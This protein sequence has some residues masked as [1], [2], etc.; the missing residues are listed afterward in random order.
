MKNRILSTILLLVLLVSLTGNAQAISPAMP[1]R[2]ALVYVT[3]GSPDDLSGFASTGLPMYTQ[4]D[5]AL[6]TGADRAGQQAL[7]AIGLNFQVIDPD[8]RAGTYYLAETR[9]GHPAPE[10]AAYGQ[11]LLHTGNLVL[12][13]MDPSQVDPLTQAGVELQAVTLTPKPLP[14]TAQEEGIFPQAV[15]PDPIIQG[16]IDQVTEEQVYTYDRQLAGELP[17]WVDGGWYTITS[18]NTNSGTPIQKTMHYVGQHMADLPGMDVEY[19]VWS[20][21]TNPNVIGEIPGLVNPDDIFIIGA[22]IDDVNGT[23][24]ADDNASGSVATLLA[25]DIFSQYQWGCTMR[26][27]FWTGE[28]QGLLG[29][30][31]YAQR[32][33]QNGENIVGYLNLDMIA[34][35]TIGSDPVINLFYTNSIPPTLQLAQLYADVVSAYNLDLDPVLGTGVTGSDHASFW[36]YGFTSILAIEDDLGGD[37]NPYYHGSGDTPAHTDPAYFTNFVKASIATYAHMSGCLIPGDVGHL[38]GH[39]TAATGGSPIEGASI[40]AQDSSGHTFP[41]TTDANGYYTRTLMADTYV[42]TATAYSYLPASVSGVVITT[43]TVTTQDFSLVSAP[44][45]IVSGTVTES[46]T[47]VPLLAEIKFVGSPVI[48]WSDPD[49][50]FYQAELPEDSY[51]MQVRS[52]L[53]RSQERD[54]LVDHDQTQNFSLEPLPCVLL[55]D[56]DGDGPDV[57]S[58]YTTALDGLGVDY[59]I[60]DT[61]TAGDP[62]FND[63]SGYRKLLWYTGYPYFNTF[64]NA[65]E[66]AVAAFLDAGGNFFLSSQDYLYEMHLT[67]FGQNYLHIL[68]YTS[69]VDQTSVTGQN[70]FSGLGPYTLSYPFT[71]YSDIVNPDG[72]AQIAFVGNAGNAA[73]SYDGTNFNTVFLGYPFEAI[74]QLTDREAVMGRLLDFFGS[75]QPSTG[76]L[77]G[78]VT[79]ATT[80]DPL[81]GA[82]VTAIPGKAGIQ[83]ITDPNGYY[84]M[85]LPAGTYTVTAS[86][87]GYIPLSQSATIIAG[88]VTTLDF[89]L[90][91]VPCVPVTQTDFTWLPLDPVNGAMV[92]FTGTSDGSEPI[93]YTWDFGDSSGGTGIITTHTYV[94][95]G[96]YTVVLTATNACGEASAEHVVTVVPACDP[97]TDVDFTWQPITPTAGLLVTFTATASGTQPIDFLWDFGDGITATGITVTHAFST[98]DTFT[99]TLTATNACDVVLVNKDLTVLPAPWNIYLPLVS[100]Q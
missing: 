61:Q 70:V 55:V 1:D 74:P 53:H 21:D 42:V 32:A 71:N 45:Y 5:G 91:E 22:H 40:A 90:Q 29:S 47:G 11:V 20:N 89:A 69:D 16:M 84:T 35:N 19:H 44:T 63:I 98:S 18:R 3:V 9:P 60:W 99:V 93:T 15:T 64:N 12:L 31:A 8:L 51:T 39:V 82:M 54:I 68:S 58:Y 56:D 24:G 97:L 34:W 66:T 88:E 10:Y 6:L 14:T 50:G 27:A 57:D 87:T 92:T 23:P 41:A 79:D 2:T 73:V 59:D 13:R 48:V 85:T 28:E 43:D 65:N 94:D 37:F 17:V 100:K 33:F 77:D 67:P 78:Y 83:A 76:W 86:M 4:L 38:D 75:C 96:D 46:G 80:G 62:A 49:T 52:A 7:T 36:N 72:Q 95:S 26:F 81:A 30:D 25:A